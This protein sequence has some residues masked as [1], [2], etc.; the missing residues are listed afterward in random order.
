LLAPATMASGFCFALGR[1]LRL[2]FLASFLL[3]QSR[4][5]VHFFSEQS[6]LKLARDLGSGKSLFLTM[7]AGPCSRATPLVGVRLNG[8]LLGP[9]VGYLV[10]FDTV[11]VAAPS[12]FYVDAWL[13]GA[14]RGDTLPGFD[15]IFLA[16]TWVVR[17]HPPDGG[18]GVRENGD[19]A[20]RPP[21]R[22]PILVPCSRPFTAASPHTTLCSR[23]CGGLFSSILVTVLSFV[24]VWVDGSS[25]ALLVACLEAS[26]GNRT[27]QAR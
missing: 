5:C 23:P 11:V 15:R 13:P 12:D 9:L 20:S 22:R 14:E 4:A 8:G 26:G 1:Y 19:R 24:P 18:L 2:P 16:Q 17:G 27:R 21:V 7:R 10:A 25:S 6:R 3:T